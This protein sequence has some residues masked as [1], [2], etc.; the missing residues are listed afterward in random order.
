MEAFQP[1]HQADRRK[2]YSALLAGFGSQMHEEQFA[3]SMDAL[4]ELAEALE[5]IGEAIKE[6]SRGRW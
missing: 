6:V 2:D 3:Q 5:E 4:Q 1:T